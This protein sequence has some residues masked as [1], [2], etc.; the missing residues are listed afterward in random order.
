MRMF[1][2]KLLGVEWSY[3]MGVFDDPSEHC[4][5]TRVLMYGIQRNPVI[6]HK[7]DSDE[8]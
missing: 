8:V 3:D 2:R 1:R 6:Q 5:Y 4:V 7:D